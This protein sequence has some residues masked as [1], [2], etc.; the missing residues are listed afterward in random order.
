MA[1][2]DAVIL[3]GGTNKGKLRDY[4]VENYEAIIEID[5]RPMVSFVVDTLRNC[6]LI[7]RIA[8][9]GPPEE[10]NRLFG[11]MENVLVAPGGKTPVESLINALDV[12]KSKNRIL[13]ATSDIPLIT[14]GSVTDF[15]KRCSRKQADV[16]YP[17]IPKEVN[18][19]RYPGV[20]RTYIKFKEGVFTGG[21][22]FLINPKV[23]KRCARQAEFFVENK[24]SP[25]G[26]ARLLGGRFLL[27]FFFRS[28]TLKEVETKMSNIFGIKGAVVISPFPEVGI[29]VDKPS[30]LILVRE[31]L[32][33][34]AQL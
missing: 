16:Y 17:I 11:Q 15:I 7:N 14:L 9:A 4:S 33:K 3:A 13:V 30:D 34:K 5:H 19:K 28:L 20:K 21:N 22:L 18:D 31:K 10:M 32:A 23:V 24:K 12:L 2:L 29:D 26:L 6:P 25:I 27:K 1:V 8:I